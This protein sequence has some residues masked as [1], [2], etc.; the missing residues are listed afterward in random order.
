MCR[1]SAR[2]ARSAV[3]GA[4]AAVAGAGATVAP[5]AV[6]AV[7]E[8]AL[9]GEVALAGSAVGAAL[10]ADHADKT[11]PLLRYAVAPVR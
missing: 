5:L 4:M 7:A 6:K 3:A 8:R 10:P 9:P 11:E 1:P 2:H